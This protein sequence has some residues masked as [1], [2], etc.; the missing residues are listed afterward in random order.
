MTCVWFV[1]PAYL[2]FGLTEVCLRQRA[3]VIAALAEAGI[4]GRCV[5]VADDENLDI[6]RGL[7]FDVVE[8][9]NEWLGRRFN[10]GME[11]AGTHGADFIVPIGS[12]SWIDPAYLLPLPLPGRTRTSQRYAVVKADRLATIRVRDHRGA[13]PYMFHRDLL[14]KRGFRPAVDEI[15]RGVDGSTMKALAPFVRPK[16]RSLHALQYVGFRGEPHITRYE[17]LVRR[18]GEAEFADPWPRLAGVYPLELV[19]A[20]RRA[21]A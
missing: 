14:A 21:I 2:R 15:S 9:D 11:Y 16:D 17:N 5:V 4:E 10:D 8:R 3:T 20:A 1:T 7:G 13:G 6:A 12:D 19:E 18:W